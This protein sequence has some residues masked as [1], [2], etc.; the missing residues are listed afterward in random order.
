[1]G[2]DRVMHLFEVY[3]NHSAENNSGKLRSTDQMLTAVLLK[4]RVS[5]A[6]QPVI[7]AG[8]IIALPTVFSC[9]AENH[10]LWLLD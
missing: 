10:C 4:A 5:C 7:N 9:V 6:G 3:G 2:K 1:M 8:D